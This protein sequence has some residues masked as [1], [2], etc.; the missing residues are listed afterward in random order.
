MSTD[1]RW[2]AKA[3]PEGRGWA[4]DLGGGR[5][6]MQ[7]L[8]EQKG[9]RYVNLDLRPARCYAPL[10]GD[11]H[12]LP[13]KDGVFSLVVLKDALEH[14]EDP[15][16]AIAE[17]RPVL[18]EGGTMVIWLPFM[19][20]FHGDDFYR[21]TPLAF[22]KLLRGFKLVHFDTPPWVFSFLGLALTEIVKRLGAPTLER[23][24]RDLAWRFDQAL[25]HPPA[26]PRSFAGR[27]LIVAVKEAKR[28]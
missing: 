22:E 23:P 6:A 12:V 18:M 7:G 1:V 25:Q 8:L 17:A 10:C 26:K 27:Y 3:T 13:F 9:W 14:F 11:A 2:L 15:W 16:R 21:Y 4:L 20:P 5:A 19:W 24:I 28:P